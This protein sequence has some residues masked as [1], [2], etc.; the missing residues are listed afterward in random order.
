MNMCFMDN[1]IWDYDYI[2]YC[3]M[4]FC[5]ENG[6]FLDDLVLSYLILKYLICE[7]GFVQILIML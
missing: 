4:L 3:I 2:K 5:D 1:W 6:M 7:Y